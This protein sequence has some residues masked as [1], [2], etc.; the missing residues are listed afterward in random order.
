MEI[1]PTIPQA[2]FLSLNCK[3]PLFVAGYGSGK[4]HALITSAL[5]DLFSY[6]GARV[7]IYS[8]TYDQ[9]RLN[10]I[11]RIEDMLSESGIPYQFNRTEYTITVGSNQLIL[12]SIDNPKRIIG[13]EVFRSHVDEIEA[14]TNKD[15]ANDVWRRILSRNRQKCGTLQNRVS[16]YTTPDQGFG[17]TYEKWRGNTGDYQYVRAGT[18]SNPYLPSD[19]IDSLLNDYP[20]ELAE[21]YINGEW[22]NLTAGSVYTAFDRKLSHSDREV[23]PGEPLFIGM[24][25]NVNNMAAIVFVNDA[26]GTVAADELVGYADTPA[27]IEAIKNRYD[28]HRIFVYPDASGQNTSSKGAST[29]DITLL[30][31]AG[32]IVKAPNRNPRVRDRIVCVNARIADGTVRVN[33]K[34]CPQLTESLEKQA[35]DKHGEPDK[36]Q[37]Y[38]HANDGFGYRIIYDYPLRSKSN[39]NIYAR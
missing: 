12:R 34:K 20:A 6:D 19:Y 32:F 3:Y 9:L 4:T 2:E 7:A 17:F 39:R 25:F 33:T 21:A 27:T 31:A 26:S 30:K 10:L 18:S 23:Q 8:D 5:V 35:Y 15:K 29:S 11:P 24:D 37:G 14:A 22:C 1:R 38:D 36:T 28:G 13:Y 16:A